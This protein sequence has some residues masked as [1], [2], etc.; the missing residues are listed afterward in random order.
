[1]SENQLEGECFNPA[2]QTLAPPLCDLDC[3]VS[4][5]TEFQLEFVNVPDWVLDN[6]ELYD[7]LWTL[8]NLNSK[9]Y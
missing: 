8:K 6:D 3:L 2:A 1:M 7:F 4:F 5:R 9:I